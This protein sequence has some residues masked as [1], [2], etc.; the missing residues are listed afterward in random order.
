M[1]KT[2]HGLS[3]TRQY[4]IFFGINKRCN[5]KNSKQ[6]NNYGGRGIKLEWKTF[7]DFWNDMKDTYQDN[8]TIERI[9]NN[10]NYN[11]ENCKW[12]T[13]KK[14]ARN[15]RNNKMLTYK[16]KTKCLAEWC[17][18]LMLTS[19]TVNRRLRD[20]WSVKDAF[21]KPLVII[22]FK[23]VNQLSKKNKLITQF[24]SISETSK[25]MNICISGISK[26]CL[27]KRKTA[28]GFIWKYV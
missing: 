5:N 17:E 13:D 23:P 26:A 10:G 21:E 19:A 9:D 11:K 27:G 7:E 3:N 6:Y 24:S 18:M 1:G 25:K 8:L 16:G 28:G 20:N 22:G 14:Q 2:T 4:K 12:I 15:R